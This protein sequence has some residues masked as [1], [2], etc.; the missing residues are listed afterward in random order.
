MN[1]QPALNDILVNHISIHSTQKYVSTAVT[2][3]MAG[4]HTCPCCCST[5]LRHMRSGEIYWR[6]SSCYQEMPV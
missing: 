5:L 1:S 6:C 4:R 2:Q 3:A